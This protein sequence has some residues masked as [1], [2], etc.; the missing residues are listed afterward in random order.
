LQRRLKNLEVSDLFQ[1]RGSMPMSEAAFP[2][3]GSRGTSSEVLQFARCAAWPLRCAA[4]RR[5]GR[6]ASASAGASTSGGSLTDS[7]PPR[8]SIILSLSF[9]L[10][11]V[12]QPRLFISLCLISRNSRTLSA[13]KSY[14]MFRRSLVHGSETRPKHCNFESVSL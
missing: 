8:A 1:E 6:R 14:R 7:L 9:V 5:C 11:S 12:A 2:F 10:K 13:D 3:R 4:V